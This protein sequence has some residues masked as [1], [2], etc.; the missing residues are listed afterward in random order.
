[1][2]F[3]PDWVMNLNIMP[4]DI[5]S[6]L[7]TKTS[8]NDHIKPE[9]FN[10]VNPYAISWINL[11]NYLNQRGYSISLIPAKKWKD[12]FLKKISQDN[13]LYALYALYI[14]REDLDWMNSLYNIS[15]ANNHNML[16]AFN[17]CNLELPEINYQLLNIYFSFLEKKGFLSYETKDKS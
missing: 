14:N 13:T 15:S 17:K 3:A 7:I 16:N 5:V 4:V 12:C 11:V 9:V 8:L 10:I 2:K 6:K 1:M